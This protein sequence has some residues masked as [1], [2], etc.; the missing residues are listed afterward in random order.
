MY[1]WN[2]IHNTRPEQS[3]G[4]CLQEWIWIEILHRI[5]NYSKQKMTS[6]FAIE[7]GNNSSIGFFSSLNYSENIGVIFVD[8]YTVSFRWGI[9]LKYIFRRQNLTQKL[10][11]LNNLVVQG[12]WKQHKLSPII[13]QIKARKMG[14][15]WFY[16]GWSIK[17]LFETHGRQTWIHP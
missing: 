5:I 15:E 16:H 14:K 2:T 3:S 10:N 17:R 1:R 13:L 11:W 12:L 6:T 9:F 8:R 7:T 4:V